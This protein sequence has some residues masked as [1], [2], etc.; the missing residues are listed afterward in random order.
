MNTVTTEIWQDCRLDVDIMIVNIFKQT[1]LLPLQP[2]DSFKS[3]EVSRLSSMKI[4]SVKTSEYI[5]TIYKKD[6]ITYPE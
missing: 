6:T 3:P 1:Q 4:G 5:D 2:P